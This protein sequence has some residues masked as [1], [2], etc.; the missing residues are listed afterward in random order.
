L[1]IVCFVRNY[2]TKGSHDIFYNPSPFPSD[3]SFLELPMDADAIRFSFKPPF[4]DRPTTNVRLIPYV[5][6]FPSFPTL[7]DKI[8]H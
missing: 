1:R 3:C 6:P 7:L 8:Q 4:P 2:P 5:F